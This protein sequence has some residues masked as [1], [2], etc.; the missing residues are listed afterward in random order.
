MD[1]SSSLERVSKAFMGDVTTR[2]C[3]QLLVDQRY[4]FLQGVFVAPAPSLRRPVTSRDDGSPITLN[5]SR[6]YPLLREV[7]TLLPWLST[8][9]VEQKKTFHGCKF[10][11]AIHA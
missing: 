1:Q 6:T 9:P 10:F 3:M 11:T 4:Q 8:R 2:R 7:I 5:E